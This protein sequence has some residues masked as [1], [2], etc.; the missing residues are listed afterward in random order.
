MVM[1]RV[2]LIFDPRRMLVA[3]GIFAF[4]MVMLNHFIVLSSP[5]YA[6]FLFQEPAAAPATGTTA[7]P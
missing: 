1:W 7:T 2:W 4:F 6:D 3:I 5:R